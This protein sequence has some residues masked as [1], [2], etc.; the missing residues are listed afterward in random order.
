MSDP[1]ADALDAFVPAFDSVRGDWAAILEVAAPVRRARRRWRP[2]LAAAVAVTALAGAGVAIAAGL[3]AFNGISA[4][5]H[6]PT[7]EDRLDPAVAASL[8]AGGNELGLEPN[9]ARFV[10]QL[11]DGA[12]IYAVA[13]KTGQLCAVAERLP[14]TDTKGGAATAGCGSPLSQ[15]QPT[16]A[17]SFQA[18]DSTPPISWGIALDNV[19]AVSFT[20][21][22]QEVTVPVR[23]NVWAYEGV[24]LDGIS[25]LTVHFKDGST[26]VLK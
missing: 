9:S 21:G 4:A 26:T 13:T 12:R 3:G 23:N 10:T 16:T 5:Q 22:G 18:N 25:P 20:A 11:A 14:G 19:A 15:S 24:G 2:A 7:A 6:P 8:A 17:E 1:I